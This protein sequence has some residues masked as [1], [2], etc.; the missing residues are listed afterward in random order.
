MERG[1]RRARPDRLPVGR[2]AE[3]DAAA[4]LG[5]LGVQ[6][7]EPDRLL[8]RPAA[9]PGDARHGDTPTSAP[10]RARTPAAIAAAVSAETAP[11]SA[12]S[13]GGTPSSRL[14]H[15]VRVGDDAAQEDVARARAPTSAA[16]R[17]ARRCTTRPSRASSRA[18]GR[19]S[20]TSSSTGRSSRANR[21]RSSGSASARSSSSRPRLR[22]RVDEQ[23]DVD[24]EVAR[25]DRRL[26]A[27]PVAAGV[28]ERLRDRRLARAVEAQHAPR[29]AAARA[30]ARAAPARSRARAA[31]AAAAPRGGPG[32]T[33][34]GA[35]RRC[36][37]T[38][39]GAVPASPS[40]TA[41]SGQRRLL[42]H[43]RLEV[44]VRPA[45]AA[46]RPRAR[47]RRSPRAAPSSSTSVAAGGPRDE[48]DRAVVVRRPEPAG[49]D[50]Q[51]GVER[52]P[53]APPR[54]RR[55]R[56]PTIVIRAGSS[57]SSSSLRGEERAVQVG[58][59]AADELAAG[60]D[61]RGPRPR[62][63]QV[64]GPAGTMSPEVTIRLRGL[65]A[66]DRARRAR[67]ASSARS[68]ASRGRPRGPCAVPKRCAL[69][70][71]QRPV[72]D[73]LAARRSPRGRSGACC[74]LD[75]PHEQARR[76]AH[77]AAARACSSGELLRAR[78]RR[79]ARRRS[80]AR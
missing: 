70:L 76:R 36:S 54:A 5:R 1:D 48:L 8:R 21:Y 35:V 53:R 20:S 62:T 50:A 7:D 72:A 6:V 49:D 25:A 13:V 34:T 3:L 28:G 67:S 2:A 37:S 23:V 32:R 22:A 65:R 14:L 10:S 66:A 16:P 46:R 27:V 71:R 4:A 43:A 29:R 39:P 15:L 69:A 41:P 58:A 55:G 33:T 12:S 75:R 26:D 77:G 11:C 30:R 51:V 24:L 80:R 18:R 74:R 73:L 40:E 79:S 38:S 61:D 60:D 31:T 78:C 47:P 56:S 44:R 19:A 17:R 68:R 9:R 52:P 64:P 59:L 57:P 63:T 45:A 42:A